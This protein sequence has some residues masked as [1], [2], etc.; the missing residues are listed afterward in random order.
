M[1]LSESEAKFKFCPLLKTQDDKLKFCQV[2]NC[3]MWRWAGEAKGYCGLA[4]SPLVLQRTLEQRT[5]HREDE[6]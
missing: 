2:S 6:E 5:T 3:M 4:V 1:I